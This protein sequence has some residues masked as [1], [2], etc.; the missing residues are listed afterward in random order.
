MKIT[1]YTDGSSRG[2]PGP[3]G[4]AAVIMTEEEV[5]ELGGREDLTTN[6]RMELSG[7]LFGLKEVGVGVE[8]IEVCTDSQ[9]VKKGMTEWID[10]WIKKGWIG[11]TKKPVLNKDLWVALKEEED[12]LKKGGVKIVWKYVP[13][14]VGIVMNERADTIATMCADNAS[15]L[16]LYRGSKKDYTVLA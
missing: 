4:W 13:A 8:D 14:H 11:S 16:Q 9:Y 3:G 2:N 10:G 5:I 15:N 7:A 12:R 1:I 6:N